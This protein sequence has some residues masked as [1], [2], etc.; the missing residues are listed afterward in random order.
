VPPRAHT[1]SCASLWVE[2]EQHAPHFTDAEQDCGG[3]QQEANG[4][5]QGNCEGLEGKRVAAFCVELVAL[6]AHIL[7]SEQREDI[8][9]CVE[10]MV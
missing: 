5:L 2:G 9:T 7:N 10:R 1:P 3:R 8:M 4:L 6:V